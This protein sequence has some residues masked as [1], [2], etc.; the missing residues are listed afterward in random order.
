MTSRKATEHEYVTYIISDNICPYPEA[1]RTEVAE[2]G[3]WY[4]TLPTP[5]TH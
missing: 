3:K 4:W 1:V 5:K 2:H